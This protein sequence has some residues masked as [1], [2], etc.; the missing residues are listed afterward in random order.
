MNINPICYGT[1]N[2][3]YGLFHLS[4][5][6]YIKQFKLQHVSG[7]VN[8]RDSP[9][10]FWGCTFYNE[11]IIQTLIVAQNVVVSPKVS[12]DESDLPNFKI[13][14]F[15]IYSKEIILPGFNYNGKKNEQL[16]I[17][18]AE[19]FLNKYENDNVGHHCVNIYVT[20]V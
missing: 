15:N 1:K 10:T 7:A 13:S 17:W 12:Y 20:Y 18:Y 14:P 19:D 11:A 16:E 5:T 3:S 6:A 9:S 4:K 8:C 2:S